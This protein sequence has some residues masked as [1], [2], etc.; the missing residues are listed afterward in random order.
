MG[1]GGFGE[2][3][4]ARGGGRKEGGMV[5]GGCVGLDGGVENGGR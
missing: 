3:A 1:E 4:R 2:K 5:A